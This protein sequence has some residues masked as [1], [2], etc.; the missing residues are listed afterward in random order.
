MAEELN[1]CFP[2]IW[3]DIPGYEGWY[4]ASSEGHI[5]SMARSTPTRNRWGPCL[6]NAP[7]KI[8]QGRLCEGYRR[9]TLCV[10]GKI[11]HEFVHK[12]VALAFHGP[13][14]DRCSQVAHWD[15]DKLHN[16]PEN[17]RWATAKENAEDRVRHGLTANQFGERHSNNKLTNAQVL[18]IRSTPRYRGV[19][20]DLAKEHSVTP[21]TIGKIRRG[22]RWPH[23]L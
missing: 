18:A 20:R 3:L 16:R 9:V 2:E 23:I 21:Q 19:N 10:A 6:Y 15:G 1:K 14:P 7:E 11:K 4:Q 17:L 12:L 13:C 22:E 8:V 5:K